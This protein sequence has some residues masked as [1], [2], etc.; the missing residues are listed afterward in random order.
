MESRGPPWPMKG[1]LFDLY[2]GDPGEMVVWVKTDEGK[3]P[4]VS[5]G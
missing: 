4:R 2:P 3:T 1:W 5:I